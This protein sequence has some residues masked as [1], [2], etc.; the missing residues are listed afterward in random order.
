MPAL[1]ILTMLQYLQRAAP[2]AAA[3]RRAI[4]LMRRGRPLI[5]LVLQLRM[6]MPFVVADGGRSLMLSSP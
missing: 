6:S 4:A 2:K 5:S 1:S 3:P